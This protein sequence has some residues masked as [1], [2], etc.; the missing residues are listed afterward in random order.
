MTDK[1]LSQTLLRVSPK[2][3]SKMLAARSEE[4]LAESRT[5]RDRGHMLSLRSQALAHQ[6]LH[7]KK[8]L[9]R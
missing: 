9:H 6:S 1:T 3:D 7:A 8:A 4:L 2:G 5:L